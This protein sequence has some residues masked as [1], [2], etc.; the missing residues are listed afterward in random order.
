MDMEE[1]CAEDMENG[2]HLYQSLNVS[3]KRGYALRQ[4]NSYQIV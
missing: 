2:I 1:V 3:K 4:L